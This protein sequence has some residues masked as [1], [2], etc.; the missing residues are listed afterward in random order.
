MRMCE[1]ALFILPV[2][3]KYDVTM[4]FLDP[5]FL[6]DAGIPAIRGYYRQKL[7][8][9]CVHGLPGPF[10]LKW[11]FWMQNRGRGGAMLTPKGLVLTF[12]GCLYLAA[13]FGQNRSRNATVRVR[14]DRKTVRWTIVDVTETN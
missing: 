14:T 13:T 12:V 9:L 6:C 2:L 4:V 5:D 11:M 10:G 8:Y 1:T 3:N 7:T